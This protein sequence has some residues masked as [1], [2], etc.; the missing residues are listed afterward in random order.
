[1]ETI[2]MKLYIFPDRALFR[3]GA[4]VLGLWRG[5][6]PQKGCRGR[7][8]CVFT[9]EKLSDQNI[10]IWT[11]NR[12]DIL[13]ARCIYFFFLFLQ[14]TQKRIKLFRLEFRSHFLSCLLVT[15]SHFVS[16]SRRLEF[17]NFTRE[18]T[19]I[20]KIIRIVSRLAILLCDL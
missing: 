16:S 9:T 12:F 2:S 20:N 4:D 7:P 10:M 13:W 18:N 5:R 8:P 14:A 17:R 15:R 11:L 1:M 19:K 6:C 3:F